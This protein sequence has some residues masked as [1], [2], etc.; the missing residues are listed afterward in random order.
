MPTGRASE[1]QLKQSSYPI[2]LMHSFGIF[3]AIAG[4]I[5]PVQALPAAD[6]PADA[7]AEY[8]KANYTKYEYKIPVRDGKKL[9]TQVFRPKDTAHAYPFLLNRTPYSVGPYGPDNYPAMLGPSE[10]FAREGYIFVKQDVRGRYL[11]EGTFVEMTPHID[12]HRNASDVDESSDTYDTIDWLLKNVPGNNGKAGIY[13]ISYPGFYSIASILDAHPALVAASPQA[14]MMD[15]FFGDDAYHNGAFMLAANFGF[16]TFFKVRGEPAPPRKGEEQFQFGTPDGYDFYLRMGS[17][18]NG[19]EKYLKKQNHYWTDQVDHST[20]DDWWKQ[21][22]VAPHIHDIRPAVLTVGGWFD[23]EDLQ[24]PLR[25]FRTIQAQSPK[26][27]SRIVMGPWVHGGWSRG[28]GN[29]LGNVSFRADTAVFFRDEIQFPFFEQMLKGKAD[30]KLPRA[31]MFETGTDQWMKFEAWPPPAA[32]KQSFFLSAEGKLA[33]AAG[34]GSAFSQYLSDPNKPV[35]FTMHTENEVPQDYMD[36]DQRFA[37]ARPDVLVFETEPLDH[38]VVVA[39]PIHVHLRAS[40]SGTDSDFDVKLIDVYPN[41][42]ADPDPNPDGVHMA[43]YQ[44]LVRGDPFRGKF[45]KGFEKPVP[46]QPN[47]PDVIDWNMPDVLHSFRTGHRMMVQVQ[48]SWFP[49]TDRNPQKF[50]DIPN[51][52][53]ADFRTAIQKIFADSYIEIGIIP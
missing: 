53:A 47:L 50:G 46:F 5:V 16:Y 49:L 26:T 42:Y 10:K 9:F 23:A 12:V 11:S 33:T 39:G 37:A 4:V 7:L 45:R 6:K 36:A 30:A 1:I 52:H 31:Y 29:H 17:L 35:P 13:G 2:G 18:A 40:T 41:D 19:D 28:E 14:P 43:G 32:R 48:S 34:L 20:Y 21:R 44:Q 15:L 38:D 3:L 51:M 22:A 24:G 8:I 25:L 27:D